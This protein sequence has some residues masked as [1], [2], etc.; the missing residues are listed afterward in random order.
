[1][2]AMNVAILSNGPS[3]LD[4]VEYTD[5]SPNRGSVATHDTIGRSKNDASSATDLAAVKYTTVEAITRAQY[6]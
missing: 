3:V 2:S 5:L 1:M 6:A 4:I